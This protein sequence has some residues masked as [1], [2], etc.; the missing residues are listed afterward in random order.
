V[1]IVAQVGVAL[2]LAVA[3]ALL[4]QTLR[5]VTALP[6]GYDPTTSS[7]SA[8]IREIWVSRSRG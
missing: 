8:S 6:L 5:A 7:R 4:V 2:M 3:A 1:L